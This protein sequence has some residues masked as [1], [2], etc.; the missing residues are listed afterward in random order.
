LKKIIQL[1][2]SPKRLIIENNKIQREA[3]KYVTISSTKNLE[4]KEDTFCFTESKRN[5]GIFNG[6]I[7][8][9]NTKLP[10]LLYKNGYIKNYKFYK[11]EKIIKIALKYNNKTKE[12]AILNLKRIS[13]PVKHKVY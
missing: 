1:G 9:S 5:A 3:K 10:K 4:E 13:K 6:V 7:T 8:G 12:S 11:E 2:F